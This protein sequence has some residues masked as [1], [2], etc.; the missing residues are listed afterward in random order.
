MAPAASANQ[1][2]ILL[3]LLGQELLVLCH[4][5]ELALVVL[6]DRLLQ[7]IADVDRVLVSRIN[8][9]YEALMVFQAGGLGVA[10]V[11]SGSLLECLLQGIR[12]QVLWH[13]RVR[14]GRR[15][16]ERA[17]YCIGGCRPWP[18]LDRVKE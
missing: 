12:K 14:R 13:R 16:E 15:H 17:K 3:L 9:A 11:A 18:W 1:L 8:L 6:D 7:I 10:N 5:D 4:G 2:L